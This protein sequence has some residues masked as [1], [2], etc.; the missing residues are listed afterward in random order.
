[1]TGCVPQ[2]DYNIENNNNYNNISILGV[3]QIDKIV[4]ITQETLNGN[5]LIILE[6]KNLPVLSLPKIRRNK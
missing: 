1:M 6:E 4:Q 2:A 3:R 5:R